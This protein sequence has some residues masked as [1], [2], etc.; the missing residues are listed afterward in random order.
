MIDNTVL[1]N[2]RSRFSCRKFS[3]KKVDKETLQAILEA[4][5][6]APSGGNRQ[7]WHFTVI[8]SDEGKDLLLKAAGSTPPPGFPE[9][10]QWPYQGDFCGAPV[11][12]LISGAPDVPWPEVGPR[13]AAQNIMLAAQSLGLAT[14]WSS[15]FTKDLFRDEESAAVK[16]K[17]MPENYNVYAAL[18]LGYPEER[19]NTRP[20]RRENV[21]TWI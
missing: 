5:K 13:L 1:E 19:P 18:F 15:L 14:L 12:I 16:T 6:Y 11:V 17:L 2:I 8:E 10:L 4:G 20:P 21:E 7:G 3:S 9:K